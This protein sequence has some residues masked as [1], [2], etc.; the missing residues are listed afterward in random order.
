MLALCVLLADERRQVVGGTGY[1]G[2]GN[3]ELERHGDAPLSNAFRDRLM[4][5]LGRKIATRTRAVAE[6]AGCIF[7]FATLTLCVT[8]LSPRPGSCH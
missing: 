8:H 1:E 3:F 6:R 4:K 2:D 5:Y 7:L